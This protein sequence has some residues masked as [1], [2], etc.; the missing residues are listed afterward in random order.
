MKSFGNKTIKS[1]NVQIEIFVE[2]SG[3]KLQVEMNRW[4]E[5]NSVEII[6]ID[7]TNNNNYI[8]A[9]VLYRVD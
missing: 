5:E 3:G 1:D 6:S 2:D 4:F 9:F 8:R 7:Y